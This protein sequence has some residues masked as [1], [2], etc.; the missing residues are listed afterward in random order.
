MAQLAQNHAN[1][2][3]KNVAP[4]A[5]DSIDKIE[6][7]LYD[8]LES[9]PSNFAP[10]NKYADNFRMNFVGPDKFLTRDACFSD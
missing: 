4:V 10:T 1:R 7:D 5:N 9:L 3:N 2:L 8:Y 6:N